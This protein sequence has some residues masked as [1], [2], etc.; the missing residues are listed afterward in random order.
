[1]PLAH[2]AVVET[3]IDR[4]A[5]AARVG[6]PTAGAVLEFCGQVRDHDPEATGPVTGIEY[7][8][9]PQAAQVLPAAVTGVLARLDPSG[10][11]AVAV[12]HRVG[13]LEVGDLAL[14]AVVATPHRALGF[15]VL[16]AVV[17]AVKDEVPIWKKQFESDGRTV[18][19]NLR[20]DGG[21]G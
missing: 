13:R 9:H 4:D 15:A 14:V 18:W 11:A 1:M 2:A 19:S 7:T 21:G 3:P 5:L 20:V 8:A 12:E 10:E 17:E 6:G 16:E